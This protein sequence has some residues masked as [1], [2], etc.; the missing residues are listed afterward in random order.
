MIEI[1]LNKW[2]VAQAGI[3][4]VLRQSEAIGR[5]LKSRAGIENPFQAHCEGA[6]GELAASKAL[7]QFWGGPINNFKS[8][9]IGESIQV[10]TRSRPDGDLIVRDDD[11]DDHYY[12]LVVGQAPNYVVWGFMEGREAK[13]EKWIKNPNGRGAAY[14]VPR[15]QL[16]PLNELPELRREQ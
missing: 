15:S 8:A 10:R 12:V 2:E 11:N 3:V 7:N 1:V 16:R 9:D 6:C 4:G 13:Q 5:K 14:F